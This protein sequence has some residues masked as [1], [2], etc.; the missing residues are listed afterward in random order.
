MLIVV[1]LI[2]NKNPFFFDERYPGDYIEFN[3]T[4]LGATYPLGSLPGQQWWQTRN[5]W[6]RWQ[7]TEPC[8]CFCLF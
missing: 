1:L 6:Q 8:I 3:K 5:D 2:C 7:V 4:G